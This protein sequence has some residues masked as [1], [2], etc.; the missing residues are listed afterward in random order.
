[1]STKKTESTSLS[2]VRIAVINLS[3]EIAF[4][5]KS[6][7]EEIKAAV[8]QAISSGSPLVLQDIRGHEIIVAGEKIG[9]VDIGL[10]TERRVGF[11]AG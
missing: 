4:E 10:A 11:G 7:I 9:F 5:S 3:N 1:M 8:S 6:S 2:Q